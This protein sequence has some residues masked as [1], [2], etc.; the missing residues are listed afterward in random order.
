MPA[1]GKTLG[2]V[3]L[4]LI[5]LGLALVGACGEG[6]TAPVPVDGPNIVIILVD[7]LR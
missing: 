6:A 7:A 2:Y 1:K 5:V 3:V 4:G